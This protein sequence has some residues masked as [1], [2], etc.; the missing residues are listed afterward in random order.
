[1]IFTSPIRLMMIVGWATKTMM[2]SMMKLPYKTMQ[3]LFKYMKKWWP[4]WFSDG[5]CGLSKNQSDCRKMQEN[6]TSGQPDF[7]R[8]PRALRNIFEK[9]VSHR[10]FR[11]VSRT[12]W[13]IVFY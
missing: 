3:F 5:S 4:I 1:M 13:K 7:S 12:F 9:V 2:S 10:F 11:I 6:R 8:L